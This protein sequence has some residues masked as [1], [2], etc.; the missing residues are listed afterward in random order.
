MLPDKL[1]SAYNLL[2]TCV[3]QVAS[4]GLMIICFPADTLREE[5]WSHRIYLG[6]NK[7][8]ISLKMTVITFSSVSLLLSLS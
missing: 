5:V 7:E 4:D 6:S 2:C 8:L 3:L 1:D